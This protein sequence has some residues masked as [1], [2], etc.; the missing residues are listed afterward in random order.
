MSNSLKI[1]LGYVAICLIWGSTWLAIRLGLDSLTPLIS[2]GLRF[3]S[4]SIIIFA[5]VF[6]KKIEMHLDSNS[7]KMYIFLAFFSFTIPFGLVYWAEQFVP[8]GLASVLFG[9]FPF[10]VFVFSW[11]ILK[12][13]SADFF[14]LASVI[15]GFIG[16][17]IIFSDSLELDIENHTL[18]LLAVLLSAIIQ[19]SNSVV[20]KKW[21]SHL[22]PFSLN[23]IPLL[24][25]GIS[26]ISLSF[27]F[28]DSSIWEFNTKAILSISY[29]AVVGTIA[30]FTIYYWLLKQINAVILALSSFITPIIALILGW[31]I[32][33]EQLS[34]KV[35]V[36][37]LFVL[38]GIL[39]A[40]FK[41]LRKYILNKK[42]L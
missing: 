33:N 2:A 14:K 20:V 1:A 41:Q 25:A 6:I 18:G 35:L 29:L 39:F 38:I 23:A 5:I 31:L 34:A 21:G 9:I 32:L 22:H 17:L 36:G 42:E 30:A 28:E 27:F 4:A 11:F 26:M 12:G 24:I 16:I 15:L 13:E 7:I 10:S 19:G 37:A 3:L 40:N 8:S